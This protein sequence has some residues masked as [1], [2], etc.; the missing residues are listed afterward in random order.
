MVEPEIL[1]GSSDEEDEKM[2][3]GHTMGK[4]VIP[5]DAM[6]SDEEDEMNEDEVEKRRAAKRQELLNRRAQ[7]EADIIMEE[8]EI[9]QEESSEDTSE[10]EEYTGAIS[11]CLGDILMTKFGLKFQILKRKTLGHV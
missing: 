6:E 10:Y 8:D 11:L 4:V 5:G 2:D 7:E 9:K 1:E 3:E